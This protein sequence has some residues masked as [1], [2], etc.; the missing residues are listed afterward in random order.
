VSGDDAPAGDG[1][2][3]GDGIV[4]A[5]WYGT[6]VFAV[7]A[8]GADLA[9]FLR[10]LALAVAAALFV[11]G[12]GVFLIAYGRGVAR[13]RTERVS[14]PGLFFLSDSAPSDVRRSLLGSLAVEIALA[15]VTAA[16]RPYTSLAAGTLVPVYG[17]ALCGL[18]SAKH[19]TFPRR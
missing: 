5:S 8:V 9:S 19:G 1:V 2:P 6:A 18:W 15:L 13:S 4:R 7:T 14:V 11:V 17:L 16:V 12:C 3:V 10:P